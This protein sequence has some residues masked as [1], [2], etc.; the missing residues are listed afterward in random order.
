MARIAARIFSRE[1]TGQRKRFLL[2]F[3]NGTDLLTRPIAAASAPVKVAPVAVYSSRLPVPY[4]IGHRFA[5]QVAGR[6]APIDLRGSKI[7]FSFARCQVA[8]HQWRK[9]SCRN[10]SQ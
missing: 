1:L 6:Y 5:H 8:R 2:R 3:S 7:A 10:T 4:R 9:G